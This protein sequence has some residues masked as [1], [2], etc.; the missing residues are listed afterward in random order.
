MIKCYTLEFEKMDVKITSILKK[1]PIVKPE[2]KP[3]DIQHL[4]IGIIRKEHWSIVYKRKEGE[5]VQN[6][7]FFLR[8]KHLYS[9]STLKTIL[10]SAEAHKANSS[11]DFKCV[12]DMIRWYMSVRG[13]LLKIMP[14]IFVAQGQP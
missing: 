1:R 2:E 8:D 6:C 5:V 4:K 9:S 12:A 7:M 14:K 3:K 13:S 10:V 11:A